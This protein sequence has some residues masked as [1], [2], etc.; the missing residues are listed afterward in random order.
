M[1]FN[2]DLLDKFERLGGIF[3][4]FRYVID[5]AFILIVILYFS[6]HFLLLF[7]FLCEIFFISLGL[8][9]QILYLLL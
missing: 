3:V 6:H 7:I 5:F 9:G 8:F 4:I 2:V 1:D